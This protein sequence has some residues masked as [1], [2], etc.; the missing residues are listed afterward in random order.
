MIQGPYR[1]NSYP[2]FCFRR[3]ARDLAVLF[4]QGVALGTGIALALSHVS[5]QSFV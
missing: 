1:N 4:L 3:V 2:A 5:I